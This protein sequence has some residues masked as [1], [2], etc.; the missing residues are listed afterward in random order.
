M[1]PILLF[2][3]STLVPE[4]VSQIIGVGSITIYHVR[5]KWSLRYSEKKIHKGFLKLFFSHIYSFV[6]KGNNTASEE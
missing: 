1:S 5:Y 2:E 3:G 6:N 4:I